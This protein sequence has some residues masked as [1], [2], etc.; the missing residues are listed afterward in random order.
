MSHWK[1]EQ[2]TMKPLIDAYMKINEADKLIVV[3]GGAAGGLSEPF[4]VI[5]ECITSVRF[6]PRGETEIAQSP[7]CLHIDGGLWDADTVKALHIAK[8]PS[9]SSICPPNTEF[10][11][12]FDDTYGAPARETLR[13]VDVP[14]RSIDSCVLKEEM[15]KPNFIKLDVHSAELPALLGAKDSLENCVG[16]LVETWNSEVHKG[17]GLHYQVEQFALENG[18]E[19][20]DSVCAARWQIKHKGQLSSVDKAR[21]IGSEALFIKSSVGD[22]LLIKK[23][24]I[25]SLFG[26]YN[27][28]R[29]LLEPN[30]QKEHEKVLY[31]AITEAQYILSSTFKN[32]LKFAIRNCKI[33]L[34][35]AF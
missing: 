13:K 27:D 17:Q 19:L 29:N 34:K 8:K 11:K 28:A 21:Y 5:E 24:F 25:L 20:Y 10:L 9:T 35:A 4:N 18:F 14:L 26:F 3:D 1:Q 32:R 12:Q 22:N 30:E 7:G 31:K 15:P 33:K 23:A 6:E 16:L 2:K